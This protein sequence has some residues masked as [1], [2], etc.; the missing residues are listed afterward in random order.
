MARSSTSFKKG[1]SG[2]PGGRP[3]EVAEV[4]ALAREHTGEAI[5]ALRS[6][7]CN[8]DEPASAR[9]AAAN[10]LLD[11][12]CGRA[13]LAITGAE[14][15]PIEADVVLSPAVLDLIARTMG[16]IRGGKIINGELLKP[17][18]EKLPVLVTSAGDDQACT[19]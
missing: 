18:A 7:M 17:D 15:G 12:G 19:G 9:V 11:R 1:Q 13:P 4:R 2:N 10:S 16:G 5:E 14:G 3:A 8:G 6:I